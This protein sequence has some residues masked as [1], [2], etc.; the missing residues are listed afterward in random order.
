MQDSMQNSMTAATWFWLLGPM[1][2]CLGLATLTY[3][4][5]K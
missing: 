3:V 1:L 5:K 2:T 4:L